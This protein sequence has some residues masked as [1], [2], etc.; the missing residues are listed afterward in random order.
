MTLPCFYPVGWLSVSLW[1]CSPQICQT[2]LLDASCLSPP[3]APAPPADS[4]GGAL[5][6]TWA[7]RSPF[8]S[9][10]A[11]GKPAHLR[12]RSGHCSVHLGG[13][14][15]PWWGAEFGLL[16]PPNVLPS[17]RPSL[18]R[19]EDPWTANFRW[20]CA[21]SNGPHYTNYILLNV[22]FIKTIYIKKQFFITAL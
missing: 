6:G 16:A 13:R 2:P 10:P 19:E 20:G 8:A 17:A 15:F 12:R 4:G 18:N 5:A 21:D 22:R 7:S 3:Q 1:C 14:R 9:S 11:L